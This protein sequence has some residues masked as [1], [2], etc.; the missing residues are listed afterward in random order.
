MREKLEE[1]EVGEKTRGEEG[2][3]RREG[4]WMN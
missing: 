2:G 4:S 1:E 3:E